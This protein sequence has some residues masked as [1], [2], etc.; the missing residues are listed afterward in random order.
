MKLEI[1]K[2]RELL[3]CQPSKEIW[4]SICRTLESLSDTELEVGLSY[5]FQHIHAWPPHLKALTIPL[6]AYCH[7]TPC[8]WR[9]VTALYLTREN[10]QLPIQKY[11]VPLS[12]L[13]NHVTILE[14]NNF[15]LKDEHMESI[16]KYKISNLSCLDLSHN[17][18][19]AKGV[20]YLE[21]SLFAGQLEVLHLNSNEIEIEGFE[22]LMLSSVFAGLTKI[23]MSGNNIGSY[24]LSVLIDSRF[25]ANLIELYCDDID[26][27]PDENPLLKNS[28]CKPTVLSLSN[29]DLSKSI[30]SIINSGIIQ[31]TTQLDLSNT[32]LGVKHF[33]DIWMSENTENLVELYFDL[34]RLNGFDL[35]GQRII[36]K[37]NLKILSIEGNGLNGY[38][39]HKF[40]SFIA[41]RK[42]LKLDL[43][44]NELGR[45][46]AY[47][48]SSFLME[49]MVKEICVNN[50]RLCSQGVSE[51]LSALGMEYV[52]ILNLHSNE[53]GPAGAKALALSKNLNSLRC[54]DLGET[55]IGNEGLNVLLSSD[56]FDLLEELGLNDN[57]ISDVS[58]GM[59]SQL[60]HMQKLKRID[61]S[62]NEITDA[63]LQELANANC[64][65]ELE[66]IFLEG[67]PISEDGIQAL[68]DSSRLKN[69]TIISY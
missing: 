19:T 7:S 9:L 4:L 61:L 57:E 41:P 44:F 23:N 17:Q 5:V 59:F 11:I 27:Q 38:D 26:L 21:R 16:F 47:Y 50:T 32:S 69:L 34:N 55:S 20:K 1:E 13:I 58:L 14:L 15:G 36:R 56:G 63:G 6:S 43:S 28:L 35:S 52:H 30:S 48:L 54:L 46:G 31:E 45:Q 3:F 18:L 24:G 22:E 62:Y 53:I 49:S 2:L 10:S 68:R 40:L 66:E 42:L 12:N 51:L 60:S 37:Q 25:S 29:N 64:F 65:V 33:S 8:W 67:N 39:L